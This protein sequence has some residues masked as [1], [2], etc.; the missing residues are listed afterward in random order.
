MNE[1]KEKRLDQPRLFAD[2]PGDIIIPGKVSVAPCHVVEVSPGG[3][4]LHL[5]TSWIL[6]RSFSFRLVGTT[7]I[8][9][10]TVVWRQGSELGVEFRPDQRPAWWK[11]VTE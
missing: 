7:R 10:S 11:T 6:P 1:Q 8:F 3:A 5:S 2:I 9:H 4:R